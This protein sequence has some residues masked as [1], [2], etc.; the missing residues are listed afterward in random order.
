MN[1]V[2]KSSE[3][4]PVIIVVGISVLLSL[5]VLIISD[6]FDSYLV[7]AAVLGI[8]TSVLI[9]RSILISSFRLKE[10]LVQ[11]K[12]WHYLWFLVFMSGLVFRIRD[13]NTV[14]NNPIDLWALYRIGVMG[15]VGYVL[16]VRLAMK[17]TDWLSSLFKGSVG[18]LAGYALIA[19]FS[20][21]W[22]IYPMWTL[23]K[24][25]EYLIDLALIAA[26]IFSARSIQDFKVLFDWNW[27]LMGLLAASAWIGV[28]VWPDLGLRRDIGVLGVQ[29]AGV[30]PAMETNK[31]GELGAILGIVAF[32]RFLFMKDKRFYFVIFLIAMVTMIF[33]QS[34]SPITGFLLAVVMMLFAAK[35]IGPFALTVALMFMLLSFTG[36]MDTFWEFF[37]RGQSREEFSSL[38]GRTYGWILGW[39]LFKLNP[40]TGF[41]AYAG[42]RFAVL[43]ELGKNMSTGEWSSILNTWLE[44]LIS[45]GF[46]GLLFVA[47][48]FVRTWINLLN[49][50]LSSK[51]GTLLHCLAVEAI[52]ILALISVRS[53]FT[54]NIFWHPPLLFFLVMGYTEY[55]YRHYRWTRYKK[56]IPARAFV[57]T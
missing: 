13:T 22:S 47:A 31:V 37:L 39:E 16:I 20:F 44:I 36:I 42:G 11:L 33:A 46:I 52:G 55:L 3:I 27:L 41:G 4:K 34:R 49:I 45:V 25:L 7:L 38:S 10:L 56:Q 21:L 8:P 14:Q 24:S 23:Y 1:S 17:K 54:T 19:I 15:F 2:I 9:I 40:L 26:I 30:M 5:F 43:T 12:W 53:M 35:R 51:N 29:I 28:L 50:T 48:A 18:L 32:N 57:K 6:R